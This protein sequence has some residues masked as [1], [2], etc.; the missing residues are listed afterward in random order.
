MKISRS[1]LAATTWSKS[2]Q[3]LLFLVLFL[4][5]ISTIIG[6]YYVNSKQQPSR[7]ASEN[8]KSVLP[9]VPTPIRNNTS[10]N[11][12]DIQSVTQSGGVPHV[13]TQ[14]QVNGQQIQTPQ[15]GTVHKVIQDDNGTTTVDISTDANSS[16][17]TSTNSS[18]NIELNSTTEL[19]SSSQSSQ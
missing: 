1:V 4:V 13:N 16:G 11:S 9:S 19:N 12:T 14:V 5:I 17:T 10:V 8:T 15:T 7:A 2:H 3:V 6:L 18:T